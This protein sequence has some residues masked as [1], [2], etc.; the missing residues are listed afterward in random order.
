MLGFWSGGSTPTPTN[1][2]SLTGAPA[3]EATT[4]E[5][6]LPLVRHVLSRSGSPPRTTSVRWATAVGPRWSSTRRSTASDV[7]LDP[8]G[9]AEHGA[10]LLSVD[11]KLFYTAVHRRRPPAQGWRPPGHQR[12][13][14]HRR[15]R[16]RDVLGPGRGRP[17]RRCAAGVGDLDRHPGQRRARPWRRSHLCRT[18]T[19]P[20]SGPAR[21]TFPGTAVRRRALPGAGGQRRRRRAAST[22]ADGDGNGV[23]DGV[24]AASI[25]LRAGD[26]SPQSP[27]GVSAVVTDGHVV[28]IPGRT[29]SSPCPGVARS[30]TRTST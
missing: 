23:T 11:M 14:G 20:R 17:R 30:S 12:G 25:E 1:V 4:P 24:D 27:Y 19:T 8:N 21:S 10:Q 3:I 9:G 5:Q 16:G 15:Q 7:Q 13:H 28:G 18:P 2:L 26:V 29:V 6:H 22:P